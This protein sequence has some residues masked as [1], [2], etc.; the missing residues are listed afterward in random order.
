MII[1]NYNHCNFAA[2]G[3]ALINNEHDHLAERETNKRDFNTNNFM[4][5]LLRVMAVEVTLLVSELRLD[6]S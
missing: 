1:M 6:P 3:N 2:C 4:E 5:C